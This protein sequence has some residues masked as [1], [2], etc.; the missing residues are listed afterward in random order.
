M[1][2]INE[3]N[4]NKKYYGDV[5][6]ND[7]CAFCGCPTETEDHVPSKCFLDNPYPQYLPVIP[8]CYGCNHDFSLDEEYVSCMIECMKAGT[9]DPSL[10]VR[11]KT[12]KTLLHNSR[13]QKRI[14]TQIRDFGGVFIYDIEKERFN[15]VFRKLAFG[16]LAFEND[17]L[18]WESPYSI[19]VQLIS[20][21]T[22]SQRDLFYQP[23]RG[24]FLPEVC[25]HGMEHIML[26]YEN[27]YP[28][29]YLSHWITI[30]KNRYEYCVSPDSNMVK[31]VIAEYLAVEVCIEL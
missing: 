17:K 24:D 28:I 15:K 9:A 16:H 11:E 6:K 14:S 12:R 13:L 1:N 7:I 3:M 31:F 20:E 5:R 29:S 21:M 18:S 26:F 10:I 19:N 22:D 23:Y 25:S 2:F 8:C 27:G 4:P 30:Q